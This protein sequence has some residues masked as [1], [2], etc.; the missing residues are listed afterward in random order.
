MGRDQEVDRE[1][2]GMMLFNNGKG[3]LGLGKRN[4]DNNV[5]GYFKH[6]MD[7]SFDGRLKSCE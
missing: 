6:K 3:Q 7:T 5:E 1:E 2:D 4:I